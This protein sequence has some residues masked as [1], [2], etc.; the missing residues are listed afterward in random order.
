MSL[1]A[2]C[3]RAAE[4][5]EAKGDLAA[6]CV[7]GAEEAEAKGEMARL[8]RRLFLAKRDD[9]HVGGRTSSR[10][11][12]RVRAPHEQALRYAVTGEQ[13]QERG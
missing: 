2:D 13:Q 1:A 11:E 5:A 3:V 10:P 8:S 4:E 9:S 12:Y 6:D 7:R